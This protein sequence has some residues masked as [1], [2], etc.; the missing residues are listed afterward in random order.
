MAA[1]LAIALLTTAWCC[2][3]VCAGPEQHVK[4]PVILVPGA[5]LSGRAGYDL[6]RNCSTSPCMG[7]GRCP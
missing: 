2:T 6:A 4:A 1:K 3:R 7:A 5:E